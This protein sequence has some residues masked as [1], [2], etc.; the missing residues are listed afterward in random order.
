V[1]DKFARLFKNYFADGHTE[2]SLGD[3]SGWIVTTVG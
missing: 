1:A 2:G 3:I